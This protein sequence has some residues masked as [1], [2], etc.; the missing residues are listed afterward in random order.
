MAGIG[1]KAYINRTPEQIEAFESQDPEVKRVLQRT[2]A[3]DVETIN[4]VATEEVKALQKEYCEVISE[5]AE[6]TKYTPTLTEYKILLAF[7]K[8]D[9]LGAG[10]SPTTVAKA[11]GVHVND[12]KRAM[13]SEEFLKLQKEFMLRMLA[14]RIQPII[15]TSYRVAM[16]DKGFSDRKLLLELTGMLDKS[17]HTAKD[18]ITEK[19]VD[20]VKGRLDVL[21]DRLAAKREGEIIVT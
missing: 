18:D 14:F 15:E 8:S 2:E 6:L 5:I 11:A 20:V 1:G 9:L 17:R 13:I 19:A 21:A 16:T 4:A 12:V 3:W 10:L 7:T